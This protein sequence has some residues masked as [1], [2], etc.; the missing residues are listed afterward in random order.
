MTHSPEPAPCQCVVA[1]WCERHKRLTTPGQV[2][3]CQTNP[4]YRAIQD[5]V[6]AGKP[7]TKPPPLLQRA[8]NLAVALTEFV[9]D[10]FKTV[11]PEQYAERIR[12]CDNCPGGYRSGPICTHAKCGCVIALKARGR[13]W[14]CPAGFW[15]EQQIED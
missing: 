8:W 15:P 13:A 10:G 6:A 7:E 4:A 3:S 11:S 2:E 9:A 14:K 12:T 1:G 5:R